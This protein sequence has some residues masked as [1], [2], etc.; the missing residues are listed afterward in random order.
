M[1]PRVD[2]CDSI[3]GASSFI[4]VG[5]CKA[6]TR[7]FGMTCEQRRLMARWMITASAMKEH[8]KSG[9]M[10][11]LLEIISDMVCVSGC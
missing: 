1:D 8:S 7:E 5:F 11:A 10:K 4:F 9:Y 6:L 2:G 3:A